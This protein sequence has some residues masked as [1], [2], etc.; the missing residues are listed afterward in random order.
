RFSLSWATKRARPGQKDKPSRRRMT[1][2]GTVVC[3]PSGT[4]RKRLNAASAT[5]GRA[6]PQ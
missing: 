1:A 3:V 6:H 4:A 2:T 5:S